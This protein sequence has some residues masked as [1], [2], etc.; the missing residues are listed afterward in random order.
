[1]GSSR[2]WGFGRSAFGG[3]GLGFRVSGLGG[4]G[5]GGSNLSARG[6]V[7]G[8]GGQ[9]FGRCKSFTQDARIAIQELRNTHDVGK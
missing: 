6:R 7:G 8:L 1:M 9:W 5:A 2:T 4:G 3:S